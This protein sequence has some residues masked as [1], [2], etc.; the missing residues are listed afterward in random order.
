MPAKWI[1]APWLASLERL[2]A[3]SVVRG[4][5]RRELS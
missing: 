1:H 5:A 2:A 4:N 3:S